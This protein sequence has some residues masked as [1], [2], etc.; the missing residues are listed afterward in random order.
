MTQETEALAAFLDAVEAG[1]VQARNILKGPLATWNPDQISWV[2]TNG[3]KGLYEKSQDVD[4]LEFKALVKDL[5]SHDGKLT[6]NGIFY[7][8]FQNGA[9][10]GRKKAKYEKKA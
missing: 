6:R 7:W 1:I 2:S 4:N 3:A 5:A 8:L 10:V 9:T